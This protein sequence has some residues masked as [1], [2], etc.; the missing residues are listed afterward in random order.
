MGKVSVVDN[1]SR[2][3]FDTLL[4]KQVLNKSP[5]THGEIESFGDCVPQVVIE[6]FT[7]V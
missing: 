1:L 6:V 2:Q 3:P 4:S 7:Y 5:F